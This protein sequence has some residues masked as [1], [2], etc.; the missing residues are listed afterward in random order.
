MLILRDSG[1]PCY[2][3][4][5]SKHVYTLALTSFIADGLINT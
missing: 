1:P 4:Q 3:T 2:T 5:A